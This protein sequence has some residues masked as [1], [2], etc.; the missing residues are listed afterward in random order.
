MLTFDARVKYQARIL[1]QCH[2]Y[3][4]HLPCPGQRG[5]QEEGPKGLAKAQ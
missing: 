1:A 4:R 3:E 5:R 2:W